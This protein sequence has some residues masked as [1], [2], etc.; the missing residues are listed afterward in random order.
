M[1]GSYPA[2]TTT[3]A[4]A[5]LRQHVHEILSKAPPPRRPGESPRIVVSELTIRILDFFEFDRIALRPEH[6]KK[7]Q[8]VVTHV[9]ARRRRGE[10]VRLI[11]IVGH[12]DNSGQPSYNARLGQRRAVV[13]HNRLRSR[14]EQLWPGITQ[15]IRFVL[16]SRGAAQPVA[17]NRTKA[18]RAQN[19]RVEIFLTLE[20]SV[21]SARV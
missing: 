3:A 17:D 11:R 13:D 19:R 1:I 7:I 14:L 18:G 9:I 5:K 10:P 12:T 15:G 8:H 4:L 21:P 16:E 6:L 2:K 20:K